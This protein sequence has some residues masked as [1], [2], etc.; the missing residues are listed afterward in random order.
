MYRKRSYY[1]L[2]TRVLPFREGY[3]KVLKSERLRTFL[4]VAAYTAIPHGRIKDFVNCS[5][6]PDSSLIKISIYPFNSIVKM[7]SCA[8]LKL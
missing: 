5:E 2:E 4:T 7:P 1:R 6:F 8:I 3:S